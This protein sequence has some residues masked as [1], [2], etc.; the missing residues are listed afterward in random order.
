MM[1]DRHK[2][3]AIERVKKLSKELADSESE[4]EATIVKRQ[5][6]EENLKQ[7]MEDKLSV[8]EEQLLQSLSK[9]VDDRSHVLMDLVRQTGEVSATYDFSKTYH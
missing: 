1:A 3:S 4:L 9:E 5:S 2:E 8:T 6:C 7:P